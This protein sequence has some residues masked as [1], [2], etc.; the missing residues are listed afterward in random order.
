M[1]A[2]QCVQRPFHTGRPS[3]MSMPFIGH[4]AAHLPHETHASDT[5]NAFVL[6]KKRYMPSFTG[7]DFRRSAAVGRRAG[8]SSPARMRCAAA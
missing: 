6:M 1:H 2:M 3:F 5:E 4:P 8:K 7:P